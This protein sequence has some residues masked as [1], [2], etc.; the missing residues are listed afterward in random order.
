MLNLVRPLAHHTV[1][2]LQFPQLG[3]SHN[4]ESKRYVIGGLTK[5][6]RSVSPLHLYRLD[7]WLEGK[8]RAGIGDS[9]Y[10]PIL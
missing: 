6:V 8:G 7:G 10:V 5:C 2:G 9:I 3:V 4:W 1:L